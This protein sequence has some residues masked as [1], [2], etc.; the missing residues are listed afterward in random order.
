MPENGEIEEKCMQVIRKVL[1]GAS[2]EDIRKEFILN[3]GKVVCKIESLIKTQ[4]KAYIHMDAKSIP[5]VMAAICFAEHQGQWNL[6]PDFEYKDFFIEHFQVTSSIQNRKGA[7][8]SRFRGFFDSEIA[9][10]KACETKV[11]EYGKENHSLSNLHNSIKRNLVKHIGKYHAKGKEYK[12]GIFVLDYHDN[13]IMIKKPDNEDTPYLLGEDKK[14]LGVIW[15]LLRT[16]SVNTTVV[17][18]N[19]HT[20]EIIAAECMPKLI[21]TLPDEIIWQEIGMIII[22]ISEKA[23]SFKV[24]D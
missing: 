22:G 14:A 11:S 4:M 20:V 23:G 7:H 6:F 16:M 15:D 2:I 17:F 9:S 10:P 5:D 21:E 1:F 13:G 19:A 12:Q 8:Y 18:R 24:R 3:S